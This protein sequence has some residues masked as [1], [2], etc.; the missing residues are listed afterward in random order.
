MLEPSDL[1]P[2]GQ[3]ARIEHR[4]GELAVRLAAL[5]RGLTPGC[6]IVSISDGSVIRVGPV[7]APDRSEDGAGGGQGPGDGG[8]P[9]EDPAD[10]G[11]E[12]AGHDAEREREHTAGEG[13]DGEG[14]DERNAGGDDHGDPGAGGA[15]DAGPEPSGAGEAGRDEPVPAPVKGAQWPALGMW[16]P[17]RREPGGRD[18]RLRVRRRVETLGETVRA[19]RQAVERLESICTLLGECVLLSVDPETSAH[20]RPGAAAP[21]DGGAPAGQGSAGSDAVGALLALLPALRR[22]EAGPD[23]AAA[24][25]GGEAGAGDGDLVALAQLVQYLSS[26]AETSGDDALGRLAAVLASPAFQDLL[27]ARPAESG[28]R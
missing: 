4:Q 11:G 5:S 21:A 2:L 6:T 8:P 27:R 9:A 12:E 14:S 17:G 1:T 19:L 24:A 10:Q 16:R 18:I 13:E 25:P 20:R 22:S 15:R 23:G 28:G 26:R 7:L 3:L